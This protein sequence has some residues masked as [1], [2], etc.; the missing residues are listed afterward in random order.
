M[1]ASSDF[2]RVLSKRCKI[3]AVWFEVATTACHGGQGR[4][5]SWEKLSRLYT[6]ADTNKKRANVEKRIE[7]HYALRFS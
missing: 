1:K 2:A 4:C 5:I 6:T 7:G 3:A